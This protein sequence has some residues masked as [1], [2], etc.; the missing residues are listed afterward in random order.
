[1][2]SWNRSEQ[3]S[4]SSSKKGFQ[5]GDLEHR[6][7]ERC[8]DRTEM[9]VWKKDYLL[10]AGFVLPR[11][12]NSFEQ[13][14]QCVCRVRTPALS[15][16]IKEHLVAIELST[17][18]ETRFE[19]DP[20]QIWSPNVVHSTNKH[21]SIAVSLSLAPRPL[22][23]SIWNLE[24]GNSAIPLQQIGPTGGFSPAGNINPIR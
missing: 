13:D 17:T 14:L 6:G 22:P 4:V 23:P 9:N 10:C 19:R 1:M 20:K 24:L 16:N 18:T 11:F 2:F 15:S 5:Q 3:A 7:V 8:T 21:P 12:H